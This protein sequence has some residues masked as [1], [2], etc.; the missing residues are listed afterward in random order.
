MPCLFACIDV[1]FTNVTVKVFNVRVFVFVTQ[2]NIELCARLY[3]TT[4]H[5]A[6]ACYRKRMV[7]CSGLSVISI[8]V[9]PFVKL[10]DGESAVN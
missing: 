10:Q 6:Y 2:K 4:I 9:R 8:V 7:V 1:I 3:E 5:N